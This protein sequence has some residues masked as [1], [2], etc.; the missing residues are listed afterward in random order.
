[1]GGLRFGGLDLLHHRGGTPCQTAPIALWQPHLG[2]A[3][4]RFALLSLAMLT[5]SNLRR[6]NRHGPNR[7]AAQR[8][9]T[10]TAAPKKCS[11]PIVQADHAVLGQQRRAFRRFCCA[12]G[13]VRTAGA[14]C[15][16]TSRLTSTS[17]RLKRIVSSRAL[18][19][20][21]RER[22]SNPLRGSGVSRRRTRSA[23]SRRL[24]GSTTDPG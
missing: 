7:T 22:R 6:S 10:G 2:R 23:L 9:A 3:W 13:R 16:D 21:D 1:M 20:P 12:S 19:P 8:C 24:Q 14:S 17:L 15:P 18:A 5:A 11:H 4:Q